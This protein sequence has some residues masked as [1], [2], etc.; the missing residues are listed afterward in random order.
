MMV[1]KYCILQQILDV[2]KEGNMTREIIGY[3]NGLFL[4]N[5]GKA[6]RPSEI[7]GGPRVGVT[8]DEDN[9]VIG[10]NTDPDCV[11]NVCPIK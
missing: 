6:L 11:G 2:S 9:N 5:D 3:Q 8:L 4:V 1:R 10:N 7:K